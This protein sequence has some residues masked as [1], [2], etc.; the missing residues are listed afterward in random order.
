MKCGCGPH[1]STKIEGMFG[2]DELEM[3]RK[4]QMPVL[5]MPCGTDPDTLKPGGDIAKV[6]AEKGGSSHTFSDMQHGFASRGDVKD[7]NVARDVQD[8]ITRSIDLF[9][10]RL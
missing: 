6:V 4:V 8:C 5:L 7:P 2:A 9:K 1:P 10:A 3:M